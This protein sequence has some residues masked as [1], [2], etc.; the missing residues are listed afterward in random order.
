M[1]NYKKVSKSNPIYK[2]DKSFGTQN[3]IKFLNYLNTELYPD[4]KFSMFKNE[5]S[6]MDFINSNI[7][8]LCIHLQEHIIFFL[9][10]HQSCLCLCKLHLLL[11]V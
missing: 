11:F 8:L 4:D 2:N 5:H 10:S 6:T 9:I 3:E 7:I 1:N